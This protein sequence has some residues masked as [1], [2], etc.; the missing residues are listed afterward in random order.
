MNKEALAILNKYKD[1]KVRCE[2]TN[3]TE[4]SADIYL[5]GQIVDEKPV[6]WWTGKEEEGEF[7]YPENI[8]KLVNEAGDKEINLHINSTGGSIYASIS[9]HNFLKQAKNKINVYI[10][11]IAASGASIIAMAADKI[12]MPENTTMMIHRAA[13]GVYGNVE[14]LRKVANTLE[15]FDE[16]VLNSYKERFVGEIGELKA[17]IEDETYLTATECKSLG[18]CD[19]ILNEQPEPKQP[20]QEDIKNSI[21]NKYMNNVKEPQLPTE[22]KVAENKNKMAIQNLLKNV[23]GIQ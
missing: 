8:R 12:F 3:E 11:G 2:L 4:S 5:Y 15:K 18:L 17:L 23:G 21:L 19:E 13:V 7:I 14:T 10:D 20:K 16:T 9:I 1:L 22:L 6:N